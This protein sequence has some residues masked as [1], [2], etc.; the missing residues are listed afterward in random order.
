MLAVF[1]VQVG[2][3]LYIDHL[4]IV[5]PLPEVAGPICVVV[6]LDILD[7]AAGVLRDAEGP[8]ETIGADGGL[9]A[10]LRVVLVEAQAVF[11]H[12]AGGGED[13]LPHAVFVT[14]VHGYA[15]RGALHAHARHDE[16]L[17][18]ALVLGGGQRRHPFGGVCHM[19]DGGVE[20]GVLRRDALHGLAVDREGEIGVGIGLVRQGEVPPLLL[21]RLEAVGEHGIAQDHAVRVLL[22]GDAGIVR[23]AELA[24]I[25]EGAAHIHL[26]LRD[27]I[28]QRQIHGAA[29]AV[30][31]MLG[32]IAQ[33]EQNILLELRIEVLLHAR[34]VRIQRPVH[35][36]RHRHLRAVGVKD[37]QTI[38]LP[39]EIVADLPQGGRS[40]L[41]QQ[42]HRLLVAVDPVADEIVGRV[43]ADLQDRVGHRLA[44]QHKVRGVVREDHAVIRC[45]GFFA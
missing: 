3:V 12:I 43:I 19:L 17:G 10:A 35:E 8:V 24:E 37:L 14:L 4:V 29:P 26:A 5:H 22:L 38:A 21:Q 34:I 28:K 33:G 1:H 20:A 2:I 11:P 23:V 39:N 31:G 44:E 9:G 6:H 7:G 27:H 45:R 16:E 18:D 41:R 32:D 30:A 36:I 13:L 15:R 42:R 40:L 25:V